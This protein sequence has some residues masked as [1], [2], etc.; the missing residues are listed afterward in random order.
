MGPTKQ[1]AAYVSQLKYSDTP[2]P[3]VEK[4]KECLLDYAGCTLFAAQTDMGKYITAYGTAD[5]SG[6]SS[7]LPEGKA[8]YNSTMAALINGTLCHGFELDDTMAVAIGHPGA[9]VIPPAVS[10]GEELGSSG[11]DL[12]TAIVAG[13]EVFA[14]IAATMAG[15]SIAKGFHPTGTLGV[16]GATIS[17]SKMLGLDAKTIESALGLAGSMASGL[18]QFSL[19]GSMVKRIHAGKSAMRGVMC[20][21]LAKLGF[22]GPEDIIEGQKGFSKVFSQ[23]PYDQIPWDRLTEGLGDGNYKIMDISFKPSPACGM[24]HSILDNLDVIRKDPRYSLDKVKEII[25]KGNENQVNEHNIY[26]PKSILSAQYSLPFTVG[27]HLT[28]N[29]KDASQYLSEDILKNEAA[30]AV[31]KK[32]RTQLDEEVQSYYPKF[33]G[34]RVEVVLEDG[35][36]LESYL[37]S[38]KGS[39]VNPFTWEELYEKYDALCANVVTPQVSRAIADQ[40]R[41]ADQ[42]GVRELFQR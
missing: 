40:I 20:A 13:Y 2:A 41:K 19:N 34:S 36:R 30:I 28:G 18:T 17:A 11:E 10:L 37:K 32:V 38:P 31:G 6:V 21:K 25:V 5:N 16:M 4:V 39:G 23:E 27:L 3:V 22:T 1:L 42:I 15:P 35:T 7:I 14:R 8:K 24:L 9:T 29:V 33:L 12:I 26:E